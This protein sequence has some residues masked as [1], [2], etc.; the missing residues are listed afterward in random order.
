MR[1]KIRWGILGCGNIAAKFASDLRLV[2]DAVLVAC[3]S[4]DKHKADAFAER[5]S[6]AH[7]FDSYEALAQSDLVDAVYI[8]TPH[9]CHYENTMLCLENGKATLCEK[10]FA[11]NSRQAKEMIRFAREKKLFLMEA[12]WTKF[13]PQYRKLQEIL[14]AGTLGDIHAVLVNFGFMPRTPTPARVF[15]PALAGGTMLDIGIYNVFMAMSVLGRPQSIEACM[16]PA[17]SGVDEQCAVLFRYDNGAMAQLFSSFMS[18]LPIEADI[19]G[20]K[21]RI[22]LTHRFYSLDT[23]IEYYPDGPESRQA[24][25]VIK[26]AEG[27]GYQ[28]EA[29]HVCDCLRKGLAE[30]PVMTHADTLSLMEV[31]DEIRRKSGIRY[32]EDRE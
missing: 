15:D 25:D 6:A 22:K 19:C 18:Q 32:A 16:K 5:F 20:T 26:D 14:Q 4:R 7:A 10:A 1:D 11:V 28:Y 8:A 30:S 31:L 21:G 27:H 13:L 29:R 23:A 12:L 24:I 2:D 3:G 9:S 17:Y